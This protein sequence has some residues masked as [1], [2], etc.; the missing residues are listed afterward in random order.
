MNFAKLKA[1]HL[2]AHLHV[3]KWFRDE[4][5]VFSTNVIAL[6]KQR[7]ANARTMTMNLAMPCVKICRQVLLDFVWMISV[8]V[9]HELQLL[10]RFFSNAHSHSHTHTHHQ[11]GVVNILLL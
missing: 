11:H 6:K 10:P 2:I 7:S 5:T 4:A 3:K 1:I 9:L 8:T